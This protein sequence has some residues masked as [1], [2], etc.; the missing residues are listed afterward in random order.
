[1]SQ[2]PG[3][4]AILQAV[5]RRADADT[6]PSFF[7]FVILP[8]LFALIGL[9]IFFAAI[10]VAA[11][12][13]DSSA[14][15]AEAFTGAALGAMLIMVAAVIAGIV[16]QVLGLYKV[17]KRRNDHIARD[18]LLR[19]GTLEFARHH[20]ERAPQEGGDEALA[21]MERIH[22]EAQLE[23]NER[24]APLHLVLYFLIPFWSFYVL[25]FLLKDLPRHSRRQAWFTHH[26]RTALGGHG[27]EEVDA[28][29]ALHEH[30]FILA[31]LGM[32]IIPFWGLVVLYWIYNDPH[33]H[34]D[35]QWRHEDQ[36]VRR[37]TVELSSVPAA[38]SRERT[39]TGAGTADAPSYT[40][41]ACVECGKRYRVPP[42][43][44]VRVT[45]KNCQ[46]Q[47]ILKE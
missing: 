15:A 37:T 18:Q 17:I 35:A 41:W 36:L 12:T 23:E 21:A 30:N 8:I 44:P 2:A 31:L 22:N 4:S 24:S 40:V 34:F 19:Q 26:A 25:Y 42:K 45:C 11:G 39:P 5:E 29:P 28:V 14:A 43:R 16:L 46:H 32:I 7:T 27:G 33:Q 13:A 6:R 10:I 1:M 20:H 47:E 9:A 3:A 38:T